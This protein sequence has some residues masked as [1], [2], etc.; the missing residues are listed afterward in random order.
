M[1]AIY[2]SEKIFVISP[3]FILIV[4]AFTWVMN[5]TSRAWGPPFIYKQTVE[6]ALYCL[7]VLCTVVVCMHKNLLNLSSALTRVVCWC[8]CR[9]FGINSAVLRWWLVTQ[10]L[11]V[12][13]PTRLKAPV[14][15]RWPASDSTWVQIPI[16]YVHRQTPHWPLWPA[17][18]WPD[19]HATGLRRGYDWVTM[20][21]RLSVQVSPR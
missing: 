5:K 12:F 2:I 14:T 6:M 15:L 1:P 3:A 20:S 10:R 18:H 13:E 8:F 19:L 21:L 11:P 7:R 16:S 4:F 17:W 9:C